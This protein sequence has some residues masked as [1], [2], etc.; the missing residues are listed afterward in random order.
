MPVWY[1]S[2]PY[3]TKGY[4]ITPYRQVDLLVYTYRSLVSGLVDIVLIVGQA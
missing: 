4:L 2:A 1:Q 3:I